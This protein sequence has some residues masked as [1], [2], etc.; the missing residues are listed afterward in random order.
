MVPRFVVGGVFWGLI[1]CIAVALLLAP[2]PWQN[3]QLDEIRDYVRVYSWWAGLINLVPLT[4]LALT[5]RWWARPLPVALREIAETPD[6]IF[7]MRRR[8]DGRLR[9]YGVFR[10]W[11]KSLWEDEDKRFAEDIVE[12]DRVNADGKCRGGKYFPW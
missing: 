5:I 10:G 1:C 6:R 9:R 11:A 3:P 2:K 8:R 12:G 7:A 4:I